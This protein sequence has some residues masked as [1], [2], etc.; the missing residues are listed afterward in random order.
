MKRHYLTWSDIIWKD[1]CEIDQHQTTTELNKH[2]LCV[3]LSS[4]CDEYHDLLID[5]TNIPA[6]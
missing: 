3:W 4:L 6:G 2:R 1:K 5:I